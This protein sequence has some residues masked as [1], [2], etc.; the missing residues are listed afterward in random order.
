MTIKDLLVHVDLS[1]TSQARIDYAFGL[2][3]AHKAH[4]IG[5]GYSPLGIVPYYG[6]PNLV[7]PVPVDYFDKLREEA[8]KALDNF[9]SVGERRGLSVETRL[10]DCDPSTCPT[11]WRCTPAMRISP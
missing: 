7:M 3:E 8:R 11:R 10:I 9:A 5:V 4:V 2:A 6:A 1:K